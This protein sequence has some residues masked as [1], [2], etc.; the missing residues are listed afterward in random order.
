MIKIIGIETMG[1]K[2][3]VL[4][5]ICCKQRKCSIFHMTVLNLS[6]LNIF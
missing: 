6:K 1:L 2:P 3:L 4:A 5:Q